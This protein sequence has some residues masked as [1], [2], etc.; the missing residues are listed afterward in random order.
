M[1]GTGDSNFDVSAT[2]AEERPC[3][4]G[5]GLSAAPAGARPRARVPEG[6]AGRPDPRRAS[7]R[8]APHLIL[9]HSKFLKITHV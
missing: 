7:R 8:A 5:P 3:T 6:L 1:L 9:Y 2:D 4:G